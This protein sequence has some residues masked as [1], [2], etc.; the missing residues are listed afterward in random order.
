MDKNK[1]FSQIP[2]EELYRILDTSRNG[3]SLVQAG[4]RIRLQQQRLK[5]ESR[6]RREIRLLFRQFF[7]PLVLL[8]LLAVILSAWIGEASDTILILFILLASG[9]LGFFQELS[10]GRALEKLRSLIEMKHD[11]LREGKVVQVPTQEVVPGD[12]LILNAGDVIPADCRIIESSELHVN[13]A[14]LTGE[15]FPAEKEVGQLD[16]NKPLHEKTNCLWKGTNVISGTA[17]A[18][19]IHTGENTLLGQLSQSLGRI[20]ETAF[21]KGIR[22]FGYFILRITVLLSLVI[23]TTNLIFDKPVFDSILFALALAVGMAPE[24]LPAILTFAMSVGAKRMMKKK[25]IVKKLSSI[26]NFG[27]VQILCMDKTG[28]VTEGSVQVHDIVDHEGKPDPRVRLFAGLNAGLQAGYQ[29]PVDEALRSLALDFKPYSKS[30]EVPYDFI[31]KRLSVCVK[32]PNGNLIITKG[33]VS[34]IL[35]VCR[36]VQSGAEI[37]DL[38]EVSRQNIN[39]LFK[40]YSLKGFRVLGIC[41]K[42]LHREKMRREDENEMIFSGFIIL[43]DPLKAGSLESIQKLKKLNVG[44]KI[45]TGDNRHAAAYIANKLG[46]PDNAI[47]TGDQMH[48]LSPEALTVKARS[49]FV[50]AEIEP[51]QKE[52]IVKSL[53]KSHLAVAYL[54]D[55]INDV[56]AIH[57]ADTGI[58]TNNAVDVAKEAADFVLLEKDLSVLSDGIVEGR[59][60]F[61]N[62][63]KYIFITTGATFGNMLSVATASLLL[64]F[65]P[66]LPKQILLTNSI[67]DLPFLTIASDEVDKAELVA[68]RK[69]DMKLIRKFMVVFGIHSSVFDFITFYTLYYYFKLTG[70]AFQTGWFL[71]SVL[72]ELIIIFVIRTKKSF[73]RS[74]PGNLLLA[75]GSLAFILT[76]WL[77]VSPFAPALGLSLAHVQQ[78]IA[79]LIIMLAYTLTADILKIFFFKYVKTED[80]NPVVK[81]LPVQKE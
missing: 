37:K 81:E 77:P 56:A 25:V 7:N 75:F 36:F 35:E 22:N 33:A 24:L 54:G 39:A 8:L 46:L 63:M 34:S 55:G 71:E 31:R 32:H 29:N 44:I 17:R 65:L 72:T 52:L 48:T 18:L 76:I 1:P 16:E 60:S 68:P 80:T 21:E 57:A 50:F 41:I 62:S 30:N 79:L 67:S 11:L 6:A 5:T 14:T 20:T 51:Y 47:I 49:T 42:T 23:L 2:L 4:V 61:A 43:E 45:I 59:T 26:F 38:D 70:P 19:V 13:E 58:S 78:V 69:W 28:T 3:L 15:S 66:M 27:E 64:P 10:A 12:V 9:L 40:E 73:I 74:K 53:Q